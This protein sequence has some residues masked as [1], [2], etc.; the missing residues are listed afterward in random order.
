MSTAGIGDE[1]NTSLVQ[2]N[3]EETDDIVDELDGN[4]VISS[5]HTS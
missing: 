4:A 3:A 2:A 1:S 5:T